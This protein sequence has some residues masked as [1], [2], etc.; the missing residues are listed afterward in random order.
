MKTKQPLSS[1]QQRLWF[2]TQLSPTSSAL[3][4][5]AALRLEGELDV[6]ILDRSLIDILERHDTWRSIFP[7]KGGHPVRCVV[8]TPSSVLEIRTVDE[9]NLAACLDEDINR[10]FDIRCERPVRFILLQTEHEKSVFC[11]V[12]HHIVCDG[13]SMMVFWRE[14]CEL[15]TARISD[16]PDIIAAA[17]GTTKPSPSGMPEPENLSALSAWW[18]SYLGEAPSGC[19]LPKDFKRPRSVTLSARRYT[20]VLPA[21]TAERLQ[22]L[23][24]KEKATLYMVLLSTFSL[25][26]ARLCERQTVFVGCPMANR[27]ADTRDELGLFLDAILIKVEMDDAASFRELLKSV[28]SSCLDAFAHAEMPYER[29][30]QELRQDRSSNATPLLNVMLVH[31]NQTANPPAQLP[32]PLVAS[33]MPLA[34][35]QTIADLTLYTA[36]TSDGLTLTWEYADDLFHRGSIERWNTQLLAMLH[37]AA[38]D[39]DIDLN[40]VSAPTV[41][42]A[43]AEPLPNLYPNIPCS[44]FDTAAAQANQTALLW[45]DDHVTYEALSVRVK[46]IAAKLISLGVRT[47]TPVGVLMHRSPDMVATLL[48]VMAA[49]GAYVP[50][51]PDYPA[52]WL[53]S[54]AETI[55]PPVICIDDDLS[56][57][58]T[59]RLAS[60]T[61]AVILPVAAVPQ[62]H[63]ADAFSP[64]RSGK[65]HPDNL[66]YVL[67]TSGST[68]RPKGVMG[69]HRGVINRLS[70]MWNRW[71]YKPGDIAFHH[72]SSNFV[73]SVW[74]LFGPLLAGMTVVLAP[75]GIGY[76]PIDFLDICRR[77]HVARLT[78]VPSLLAAL[79][80]N[81]DKNEVFL[82]ELSLCISSG[83]RLPQ[84][85]ASLFMKR[86][87]QATLLNL[88]GSAEVAADVTCHRVTEDDALSASIPIGEPIADTS[89]SLLDTRA[90]AVIPGAWGEIHAAGAGLARGYFGQPALTAERFVPHPAGRTGERLYRT[91]DLGR[92]HGKNMLELGGR[93]DHEIKIRGIRIQPGMIEDILRSH[94]NVE[95]AAVLART[96]ASGRPTIFAYVVTN[97]RINSTSSL[98]GLLRDRLPMAM[99]PTAIHI[100]DR[101]PRLANGKIDRTTL[102]NMPVKP[103]VTV[104][105]QPTGKLEQ[106]LEGVWCRLLFPSSRFDD[107]APPVIDRDT[108]FFDIGGHSLLLVGLQ[109][110]IRED[111]A[112]HVEL[113]DLLRFATIRT[114]A[115][116][117]SEN[118]ENRI[119][120]DRW[121]SSRI[122]QRQRFTAARMYRG[123]KS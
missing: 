112:M 55:C 27:H 63:P 76:M 107:P 108:N 56:D 73:D 34:P 96:G 114:L 122:V 41:L 88:Y 104:P 111:L 85:L 36:Q 89:I 92:L 66:A 15:Y 98:A 68:G 31:Q 61:G 30:L 18:R 62:D 29:L 35:S 71:P 77:Q 79:L 102:L 25:L 118:D 54:I 60:A 90:R 113:I 67:F 64:D 39:M 75:A 45:F 23:A 121:Q 49:G 65:I 48:G 105:I 42:P 8:D 82:P 9:Q 28:R 100:V 2:I 99:R 116:R 106:Q 52:D 70:W 57:E 69:T 33:V 6:E 22:R 12:A 50:L 24:G 51:D 16:P 78:L 115:E 74:D 38:A 17:V 91:G 44:F 32:P 59:D 7:M 81:S 94:A 119:S 117:L 26:L 84:A 46:Q 101:L 123:R 21:T 86:C 14:L 120:L 3:H 87:P 53:Q 10:P 95:D 97:N 40:H 1:A 110:R 80:E 58:L 93:L 19:D 5:P 103:S 37:A 72:V 43:R 83:E 47:E 20:A 13:W 109:A 4:I 11:V